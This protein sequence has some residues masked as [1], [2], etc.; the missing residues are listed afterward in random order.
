MI[1]DVYSG[2]GFFF[3]PDADPW[4][5]KDLDPESRIWIRNTWKKLYLFY[6]V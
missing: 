4:F 3:I 1:R 5:K 2:F 6:S